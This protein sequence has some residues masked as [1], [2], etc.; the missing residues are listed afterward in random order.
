MHSNFFLATAA[1]IPLIVLTRAVGSGVEF[2]AVNDDA[3]HVRTLTVRWVVSGLNLT[4]W[5]LNGWAE[6]VCLDRLGTGRLPTGGTTVI[7]IALAFTAFPLAM[8]GAD[9]GP[10]V[11]M[12]NRGFRH[13]YHGLHPDR[14]VDPNQDP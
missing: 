13:L 6:F 2:E 5:I 10:G 8:A 14:A 3:E 7:W 1:V 12:V 9:P 11:W 4:T